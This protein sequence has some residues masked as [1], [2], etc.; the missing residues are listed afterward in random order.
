MSEWSPYGLT[1][2]STDSAPPTGRALERVY[3]VVHVADARRI[4]EDGRLRA[5]LIYDESRLN[6]SR[7]CVT[8]LSANTWNDG[9]IYGNV[10]FSFDWTS[11]IER[12]R[13]YWVEAMTGYSPHAFRILVTD[14]DL[15]NSRE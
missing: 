8:W 7:T 10:Q 3:H 14:R 9:S 15:S 13:F 11:V 1:T 12:Q 2:P 5:R 4:L 6:N